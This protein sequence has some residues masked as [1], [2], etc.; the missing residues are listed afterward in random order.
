MPKPRLTRTVLFGLRSLFET[1]D[2][3]HFP[4]QYRNQPIADQQAQ[5]K[6]YRWLT[7][8]QAYRDSLPAGKEP[9]TPPST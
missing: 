2:L 5:I 4:E 9:A 3:A 1:C 6:A 7:Q 8:M